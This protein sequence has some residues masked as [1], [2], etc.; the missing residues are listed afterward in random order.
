MKN[1]LEHENKVKY[2]DG[3]L[4]REQEWQW[5][6]DCIEESFE[7]KEINSWSEYLDR[8]KAARDIYSYFINI[9]EV[10][11]KEWIVKN[12]I[13][14]DIIVVSRFYLGIVDA[15]F[16][17]EA[18]Q[19]NVG[20]LLF[21]SIWVTKL[22]NQ[23]NHTTYI[24]DM[25]FFIQRNLW[26]IL[27]VDSLEL[28]VDE[29]EG[30][31]DNITVEEIDIPKSCLLDNV[32]KVGYSVR[33]GFIEKHK[34]AFLSADAI[35]YNSEKNEGLASW[36]EEYILQMLQPAIGDRE[37]KPL[38]SFGGSVSPDS[39]LWTMEVID[40][41]K[42]YFSDESTD[43]IL[44]TI[45]YIKF[46]QEPSDNTK[47]LHCRLLKELMIE[48]EDIREVIRCSSYTVISYLFE[49]KMLRTISRVTEYIGMIQEVQKISEP[50]I[51]IRLQE[52]KYPL[53]PEQKKM[54]NEYYDNLCHQIDTVSDTHSLINYLENT[55]VVKRMDTNCFQKVSKKFYQCI[56]ASA[57]DM[58]VA[59]LFYEYMVF[60]MRTNSGSINIDKRIVR[61]EIIQVQKVWEEKYYK[62]QVDGLQRITYEKE[63]PTQEVNDYN[64]LLISCPIIAAKSCMLTDEQMC[65]VM[66]DVSEHAMIYMVTR[67]H[68]SPV[69]P[70]KGDKVMFDRHDIDIML[71]QAVEKIRQEKGYRFL[72]VL[73]IDIY[74]S[75]IHKRYREVATTLVAMF[76]EEEKVYQIL[77]E[78]TE[79]ELLPYDKETKLA[80]LTQLFP[81]LEMKIRELASLVGIVPFKEKMDEFMKYKDSSSVLRE[82]IQEIY[83]EL[84]GVDNIPD[85]LFIYHF[86]YNGNSLNI[87]NEC[88]HGRDYIRGSRVKFAFRLTLLAIYMLV[89]RINVIKENMVDEEENS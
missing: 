79:L 85:L 74:V 11:D 60:L 32:N 45:A 40:N 47:L 62:E 38:M 1:Y 49:D 26:E 71:K 67:M 37:L 25:R 51:M 77:Q 61:K 16:C 89:Y 70:I 19:S 57:G 23:D 78:N 20:K 58:L 39:S 6:I 72:N 12:E 42:R 82:L 29:I 46:K 13:L 56:E 15:N 81:L 43:F 4:A 54:L 75:A 63:V 86:M 24:A 68:L 14:K 36:Q 30:Y 84:D 88:L 35:N 76:H 7:L 31:F 2:I 59:N 21:L 18:L 28:L 9:L 65:Q 53:S 34:A 48:A 5:F 83:K 64:A 66:V 41:M 87:R 33:E 73:D 50:Y 3:L 27:K 52:D 17:K 55:D 8:N 10:C 22:E 80:H 69:Y 44:E